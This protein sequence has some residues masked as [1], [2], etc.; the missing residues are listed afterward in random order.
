MVDRDVRYLLRG[1]ALV[2]QGLDGVMNEH[3]FADSPRSH[4]DDGTPHA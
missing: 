1:H 3:R 4:E 2:Q